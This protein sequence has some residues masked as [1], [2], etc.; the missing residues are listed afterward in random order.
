LSL[1]IVNEFANAKLGD[2]RL[3][4]GLLQLSGSAATLLVHQGIAWQVMALTQQG[5]APAESVKDAILE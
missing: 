5:P 1:C 2:Q 4:A 3:N